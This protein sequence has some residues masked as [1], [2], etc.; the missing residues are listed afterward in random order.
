MSQQ[1]PMA[2]Y[3][4]ADMTLFL[5]RRVDWDRLAS[6]RGGP[7]AGGADI[8][9]C[10]ML[11][12]TCDQI[13]GEI[14]EAAVAGWHE[15]ARLE[16]GR[17][18]RPA[19]VDDGYRRLREA[20]LLSPT[21]APE[22]GGAGVPLL[23]STMQLEMIGRV[24]P[25]LM[26]IVGLQQGVAADIERYGSAE[27][28]ETYLPRFVA[29]ELEG[30]MDLTE[31][32]AGSDLGGI[33]TRASEEG[34]RFF[35]DG[36]KIFI[37]NGGAQV[38]LVLARDAATFEESAGTT[39]GLTLLLC[40]RTLPDGSPN[41]VTSPKVEE[42]IGLHGSPTCVVDFEHAEAFVLG[43]RGDGFRAMLDLM[44]NARLG[45]AAQAVG[46]AEASYRAARAYAAERMQFGKPILDQP[47]VK[48][49]LTGMAINVQSARALL[50]RT[51]ALIDLSEALR[52]RLQA[53]EGTD[54]TA[55][56]AEFEA[57]TQAVRLLTPLVKYYAT[58]ISDDVTRTCIQIHGGTG[59][60]DETRAGHLHCD[61][62]ITTIYEGTSEIQASFALREIG[63][64]ALGTV[65]EGLR[66]ELAAMQDADRAPLV[67][68]VAEGIG[69]IEQTFGAL[70][71]DAGYALLEAKRVSQMV[72]DVVT[73]TELLVQAGLA[74]E[75]LVLAECFVSRHMLNLDLH[76]KRISDGDATRLA[77]YDRILGL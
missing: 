72:I 10:R 7:D 26:T 45:V 64:G 56:Q 13:C 66:A 41:G 9:V 67:R 73:G 76:A 23:V 54:A 20:G 63:K 33:R 58:E 2:D 8:D 22:Y 6:L 21:V 37:T 68:L 65:F 1:R 57:T 51:C 70:L 15:S 17:V 14:E 59:Y 74:A 24:D 43:T 49:M 30:A 28:K 36:Q 40:P 53:P 34:G 77:R 25:S 35:V 3:L 31:P 61:S 29:G 18:V 12:Q 39:K 48:G 55:L 75:K 32:G 42:K 44:N 11:L 50:Y 60:M 71:A 16:D 47:L 4:N 38:H 52:H 69:K 19:H 5:E 27:L 46:I 62:I